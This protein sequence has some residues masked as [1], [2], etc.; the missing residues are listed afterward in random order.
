MNAGIVSGLILDLRGAL[1]GAASSRQLADVTLVLPAYHPV[2]YAGSCSPPFPF[3]EIYFFL[4]VL[5]FPP[6]VLVHGSKI[7]WKDRDFKA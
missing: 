3:Y 7:V 4:Y 1:H 6:I 2:P 5:L